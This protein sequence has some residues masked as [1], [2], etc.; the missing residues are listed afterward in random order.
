M[1]VA[2]LADLSGCSGE[3]SSASLAV[4]GPPGALSE[5]DGLLIFCKIVNMGTLVVLEAELAIKAIASGFI[6]PP[7]AYL[8]DSWNCFDFVVVILSNTDFVGDH[9]STSGSISRI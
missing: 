4:E 5:E 8:K 1:T 7:S 6:N 9:M 2:C 3:T